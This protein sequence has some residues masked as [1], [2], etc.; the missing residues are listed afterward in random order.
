MP[1]FALLKLQIR[2]IEQ[3]LASTLSIHNV[4][5]ARQTRYLRKKLAALR[6]TLQTKRHAR[7]RYVAHKSKILMEKRAK[8]SH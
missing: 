8:A 7:A 1:K 5:V 4:R 3:R 2:T 6:Q